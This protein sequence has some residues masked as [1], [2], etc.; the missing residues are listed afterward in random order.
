MNAQNQLASVSDALSHQANYVYD[1]FDNLTKF[2]DISGNITSNT[3]DI[4]AD[5][6]LDGPRIR[7]WT[8]GYDVLRELTARLTPS[9]RTRR[10]AMICLGVSPRK[11]NQG[12][13]AIGST[14]PATKE[15]GKLTSGL[16]RNRLHDASE[17][18][19]LPC[20]DLRQYRAAL[21]DDVDNR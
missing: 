19:L 9:L 12:S 14:T 11:S 20:S 3:Y 10:S 2:T 8:Y 4:R 7:S 13:R 15:I 16:Y 17:L 5:A 18:D 1:A 21:D 6:R